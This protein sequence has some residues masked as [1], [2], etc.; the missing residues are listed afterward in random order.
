MQIIY[1]GGY[2][3]YGKLKGLVGSI[4]LANHPKREEIEGRIKVINFFEN[5]G[6]KVTKE[7]YGISR[8]TV[9][10]WKAKLKDSSGKLI[11][12]SP[13][14][15]APKVRR[16]KER[17][18][19]V[20]EYIKQ[21]RNKHPR[22]GQVVIKPWLDKYC[23]EN[24]IKTVAEATIGRIIKELVDKGEINDA[25]PKASFNGRSG[26]ISFIV[27]KKKRAKERIKGYKPEEAGDLVQID[28]I[29][30]QFATGI[31]KYII[32][33]IDVKTKFA[34]AYGY[35]SLSSAS[36]LDL[37][38][39]LITV[40]PFKIKRIQ[41]DNGLEFEHLFRDFLIKSKIVHFYNY[42]RSPKSNAFIERFNRTIQEQFVW[43]NEYL[44][45]D[46]NSF[47]SELINYLLWYNTERKHQS[48]KAVPLDFFISS[49]NLNLKKSN[50]L[51][52]CTNT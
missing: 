22:T 46:L 6:A 23:K 34:F 33:A 41:T 51:R 36:A 25:N 49:L 40:A 3:G 47:N 24:K 18:K 11:G 19:Q 27:K 30:L 20:V 35:E 7:A 15:R 4:E 12:L 44:I 52:Y 17:N 21:Y 31:K 38:E 48:I 29:T 50:M 26:V 28:S 1:Q 5:N 39:K 8:S 42:P 13:G 45:D 16:N 37:I 9:Y 10:L 2:L 43:S 14:S 32:T